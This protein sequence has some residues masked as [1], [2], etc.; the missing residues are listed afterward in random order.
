MPRK[1][2]NSFD[3]LLGFSRK[4]KLPLLVF[5]DI[6]LMILSIVFAV[7]LL[8]GRNSAFFSWFFYK[9]WWVIPLSLAFRI[10]MFRNF[11]L[12]HWAWEY[13]SVREIT[14]FIKAIALSSM[15]LAVSIIVFGGRD[16]PFSV[17]VIEGLLCFSFLAGVRLLIRLWREAHSRIGIK[18]EGKRILIVGAGDAGEMILREMLKLPKLGYRPIGF[19]DDNPQHKGLFIHQLPV[20]G[21]CNEIPEIVREKSIDEIIIAIPTANYK[22]IRRIV[23][24]CEESKAKFKIV[25]GIFELIDGTVHI[26]QI[27]N[28]EIE[29][30][31]GREPVN[32]DIRS[33]SSYLSN[34]NVLITGAGGS[35]GS[36][37][38]R[39]VSMY[40]PAKIIMIGKG[41]NSIFDIELELRNKYPYLLLATYI[42]DVRDI[43]RIHNI[44][45][46]ESPDV[47]FH[48][49]AH[50]HVSLMERNPD[51]SVLNNIIG[52]RNI[53]DQSEEHLV[54][55]F[56]M[57]STDKAV[58]PSSIMG[59]T[60]RVAEMMVQAKALSG[61]K[62]K[63]VSVR[64]GNVLGSRGSVVPIF[65][66]QIAGGGPVT[67]TH[68]DAK[69][70][71]MTIPEAVQL[72]I[73]AGAIGSGGEIFILDMGNPVKIVDLAKD[74]IR[75]SGLEEG[76]DIEI[77]FVGLKPGEKLFEEI[78]TSEEGAQA[79]KYEKIHVAQ[80]AKI[81]FNELIQKIEILEDLARRG[82]CVKIKEML[83]QVV[84][85]YNE[86]II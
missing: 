16:F 74:L 12:Y 68:P 37:L 50:K 73:Q 66:K 23:G 43:D 35:I 51:E 79:T 64:F 44:F 3:I 62:T 69:R 48:A 81:E 26:N 8:Q 14:S 39:Q 19:V 77:K 67:V 11:G 29:D 80:P 76:I 71:F 17:L 22:E 49:A 7:F 10:G 36:E 57:I 38:C 82:E 47:V 32:L 30:L 46:K 61:S 4:Y 65:K 2:I 15:F 31:L 55:K 58:N 9:F 53:M 60:K 72:V 59:A 34:A 75:L 18:G 24:Y 86:A 56:V 54:K 41:E 52:T 25:P 40:N 28:V 1:N 20:L 84:P 6:V 42:A 85:R 45:R 83:K 78:L 21:N 13:M 63:F 27:R 70:Y 33:I 5:S